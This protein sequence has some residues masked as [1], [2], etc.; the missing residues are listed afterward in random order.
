MRKGN[1]V[2][3]RD[4]QEKCLL[5]R[6]HKTGCLLELRGAQNIH[7]LDGTKHHTVL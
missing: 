3:P 2:T 6:G 1:I 4:L 7:S 5:T